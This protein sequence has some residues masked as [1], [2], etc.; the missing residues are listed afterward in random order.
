MLVV[1]VTGPEGGSGH[2]DS[3]IRA[4]GTLVQPSSRSHRESGIGPQ[5]QPT[6]R[7]CRGREWGTG[8]YCPVNREKSRG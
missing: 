8:D 2:Q 3:S 5:R 1:V 7:V 6:A 4:R